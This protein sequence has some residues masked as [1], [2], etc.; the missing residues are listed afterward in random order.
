MSVAFIYVTAGTADEAAAIGRA[1]VGERLAACANV[2]PAITAIYW[3]E[4]RLEEAGEAALILK[5]RVELVEALTARIKALHS[6]ACPCVVA[7]PVAG[8]NPAFL[9]WIRAETA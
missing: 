7:L 6:Y 1:V 9:D 3:W 4:G 2:L 5:T 8:G